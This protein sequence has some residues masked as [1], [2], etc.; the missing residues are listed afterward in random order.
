MR[1]A[2]LP[3]PELLPPPS[4]HIPMRAGAAIVA[5]CFA[6]FLTLLVLLRAGALSRLDTGILQAMAATGSHAMHGAA[7]EITSLGS[8][9]VV[10]LAALVVGAIVHRMGHTSSA[11]L[12]WGAITGGVLLNWGLKMLFGRQRPEIFEWRTPYAGDL[13]FPSGHAMTAMV[14]YAT[15]SLV[16]LRVLR[17]GPMRAFALGACALA[18]LSVGATRV[19]LGVHYPSD[20]LGGY[21]VGLGWAVGCALLVQRWEDS[22]RARVARR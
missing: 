12:L 2:D 15:L 4:V 6:G 21:L 14:A 8:A 22:R 19:Y 13:A 10:W 3:A 17:P 7:L 18:V 20:V 9:W 16:M 11:V 5:L 1:P